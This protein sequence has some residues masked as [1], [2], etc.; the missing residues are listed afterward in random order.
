M[1]VKTRQFLTGTTEADLFQAEE[2][3]VFLS[4]HRFQGIL[5]LKD[6]NFV[7]DEKSQTLNLRLRSQ[8]HQIAQRFHFALWM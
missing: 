4:T 6:W 7:F 3:S 5:N 2:I 8:T 1:R